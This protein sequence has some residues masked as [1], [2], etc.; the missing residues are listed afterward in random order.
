MNWGKK[1]LLVYLVFVGG[2]MLLVYKS[3]IQ[4]EE[5]VTPDYYQKELAFQHAIEERNRAQSLSSPVVFQMES[6]SLRVKFPVEMTKESLVAEVQLYCPSNKD[7]DR[8]FKM[9]I[10]NGHLSVPMR[11]VAK[12]YYEIHLR[13][14]AQN[15]GYYIEDKLFVQ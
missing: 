2:I 12:G 14:V 11:T 8:V 7:H 9:N 1:I 5:L 10:Q 13:W 3:V 6:D 4:K 15:K